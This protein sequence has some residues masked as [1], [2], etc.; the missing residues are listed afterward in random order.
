MQ[1]VN[2]GLKQIKLWKI[3]GFEDIFPKIPKKVEK[4]SNV[5]NIITNQEYNV[6]K[7]K[8]IIN[9]LNLRQK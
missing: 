7:T 3:A 8:I 6:F 5:S 2:K 4:D 1:E 9:F